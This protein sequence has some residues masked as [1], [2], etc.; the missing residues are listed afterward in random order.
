MALDTDVLVVGGGPIG[1]L[2]ALTLSLNGIKCILVERN[3][4]TTQWP[5]MDLTNC[6]SMELLQR[7]GI[8]DEWRKLGIS[9]PLLSPCLGM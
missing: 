1:L 4:H 9:A 6:R 7:L 5:K 8:A 3:Q 2:T